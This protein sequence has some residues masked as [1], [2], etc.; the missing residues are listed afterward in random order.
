MSDTDD[1]LQT[2]ADIAAEY[3]RGVTDRPVGP[4]IDAAVL[5]KVLGGDVPAGPSDAKAVITELAAAMEPGLVASA[6][7]RYFGFVIGGGLPAAV[8]PARP[9]PVRGPKA[10]LFAP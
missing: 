9:P 5:A 3:L 10:R 8:A 4:P 7:P 6:G 1:L 2:T